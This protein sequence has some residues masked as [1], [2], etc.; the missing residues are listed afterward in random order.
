MAKLRSRKPSKKLYDQGQKEANACPISPIRRQE[1]SLQG[2]C[3]NITLEWAPYQ[4]DEL[5]KSMGPISRK[6]MLGVPLLDNK[7]TKLKKGKRRTIKHWDY[8]VYLDTETY[9]KGIDVE[10]WLEIQKIADPILREVEEDKVWKSCDSIPWSIAICRCGY[11]YKYYNTYRSSPD[12][13]PK[14]LK[15]ASYLFPSEDER[16]Q[17]LK[18]FFHGITIHV[19][20]GDDY[21]DPYGVSDTRVQ[22]LILELLSDC[23]DLEVSIDF[24]GRHKKLVS[25]LVESSERPRFVAHNARYDAHHLYHSLFREYGDL[26]HFSYEKMQTALLLPNSMAH[27]ILNEDLEVIQAFY[28][29]DTFNYHRRRLSLDSFKDEVPYSLSNAFLEGDTIHYFCYCLNDWKTFPLSKYLKYIRKDI[30][31]L[32]VLDLLEKLYTNLTVDQLLQISGMHDKARFTTK[33]NTGHN[34]LNYSFLLMGI[35]IKSFDV[36]HLKHLYNEFKKEAWNEVSH[37]FIEFYDRH[38]DNDEIK[39]VFY[40]KLFQKI[41]ALDLLDPLLPRWIEVLYRSTGLSCPQDPQSVL[42]DA[43]LRPKIKHYPSDFFSTFEGTEEA[44]YRI[45]YQMNSGGFTFHNAKYKDRG[46]E[47]E[48]GEVIRSLDIN[49]SYPYQMCRGLPSGIP[50]KRP[51]PNWINP[52]KLF[53]VRL[54]SESVKWIDKYGFLGHEFEDEMGNTVKY[55]RLPLSDKQIANGLLGLLFL[56][57][58][59]FDLLR[60]MIPVGTMYVEEVWYY[61]RDK[62]VAEPLLE[63]Y[64]LRKS[65]GKGFL[66]DVLKN[67]LNSCYGKLAR[68]DYTQNVLHRN[69]V[70]LLIDNEVEDFHANVAGAFITQMGQFQL[71]KAVKEFVDRG[72]EVLGGDTDSIKVLTDIEDNEWKNF[73]DIDD[74]RLGAWKAEGLFK[75]IQYN[76]TIRKK[77]G[78]VP[79][80]EKGKNYVFK[81]SGIDTRYINAYKQTATRIKKEIR[82]ALYSSNHNICFIRA[83]LRPIETSTGSLLLIPQN[84]ETNNKVPVSYFCSLSVTGEELIFTTPE[85]EEYRYSV[86]RT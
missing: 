76:P 46:Y 69:G 70:R 36:M 54:I 51:D 37:W 6:A 16:E 50:R 41:L 74:N 66:D 2:R 81:I 42:Y 30:V 53:R 9:M 86:G 28:W 38:K 5:M 64:N 75:S 23:P 3:S 60:E 26:V 47:C 68:Q 56:F 22:T 84:V 63:L 24:T 25:K 45:I 11:L 65:V 32:F 7:S 34:F 52:V 19:P 59:Y 40:W 85:G 29:R 72:Y 15:T 55:S 8:E 14:V 57:S 80:D 4:F 21:C 20:D 1:G 17:V 12:L 43:R 44:K 79:I 35:D 39:N 62:R 61:E 48:E 77:Y 67:I 33:A 13:K 58:D 18:S 71:I 49:S 73:I 31:A 78:L 10:R 27:K 82:D 83:K